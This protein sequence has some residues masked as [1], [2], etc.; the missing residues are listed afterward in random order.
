MLLE[1]GFGSL[2][3]VSL[4]VHSLCF[5]LLFEDMNSQLTAPSALSCLVLCFPTMMVTYP[6][7]TLSP[8]KPLPLETVS[9]HD[10]LSQQ[11]KGNQYTEG[12]IGSLPAQTHKGRMVWILDL[13]G[14]YSETRQGVFLFVWGSLSLVL[15]PST[16]FFQT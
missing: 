7:Q 13:H 3:P 6:S 14:I 16:P 12:C 4:P 5:V 15:F 8:N 1:I 9:G 11:Q 10:V 2:K